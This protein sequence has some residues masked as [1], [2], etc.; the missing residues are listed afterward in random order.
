[1]TINGKT[2]KKTF[3]DKMTVYKMTFCRFKVVITIVIK[4]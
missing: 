3:V 4:L 2:L 1:M